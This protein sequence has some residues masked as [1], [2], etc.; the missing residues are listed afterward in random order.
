MSY[1]IGVGLL[2]AG[3]LLGVVSVQGDEVGSQERNSVVRAEVR[4]E[5][6]SAE[7]E[8]RAS[9]GPPGHLERPHDPYV[10]V[11]PERRRTAPALLWS[12]N[13]YVSVQVNV[14]ANGDNIVGD[15][16]NE[17]SI[18]ID[19]TSPSRMVIGWR[20][21]DTIASDFRQAGW[22]YTADGGETWTFPGVI[23]PGVFRSDP[24]LDSDTQ[25][26]FYYNSLTT[27]WTDF[28]CHVFIST[29]GGQSWDAGTYAHGGDKQW[30][31]IDRT[32]G[33]GQDN[34]YADWTSNYS[35]C[36]PGHFTRS[37]DGG[38]TYLACTSIPGDPFWGTLAIGPDGELYVCG[39]GFVVAKSSTMQDAGQPAQWDFT[40]TVNLGGSMGYSGGPNPGGLLGQVW[41]AVDRSDGPTRGNVY[42]L[43]SVDPPGADPLDVMFARSTDGGS[44]W[45][46]PVR[47]NDD[48]STSAYQWFGTMSVA[49]NGRIDIVWSDTRN[50][51]GGYDSE[52][53]YSY[54]G[55][56]G[57]TWSINQALTPAFDPHLG[58]PQQNKLGDYYDMISDDSVAHL[59]YAATFNGEQDVY[60]V[61]ISR[62]LSIGFPNGLPELLTPGE[63]TEITI[64]ILEGDESYVADS[65]TLYH[66]Y[67][68]GTFQ[69]S[70]LVPL[71]GELYRATLPAAYC[72]DTPEYY[73]SAE[74]TESGTLYQP[75]NAP[76]SYYTADVGETVI[77]MADDFDTDQGWTVEN[78]PEL[79]DGAWDRGVPVGG[80]DRGDPPTDYVDDNS[81]VDGGYTWLLSP[82]IDLS[83]GDALVQ[84]ALWYTNNFGGD[85]NNDLFKV[86]VSNDNGVNWTLVSI[87]GPYT[88]S[89]WSVHTFMVGDFLTPTGQVM[90]RFE[91]SDL[92]GGSVV[93][94]GID[95]FAVIR[96][97]C[98]EVECPGDLDGDRDVDLAD[99]AALLANYGTTSGAEYEDGDLDGDGDVDL[100]DLSALLAVYGTTCP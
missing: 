30:M 89:G 72:D 6:Q 22:G 92:A 14:D 64:Q 19:P 74:G 33:I 31:V 90:V 35:V 49:P 29:D 42:L 99:L 57:Q 59:A 53:Y 87:F 54:S 1:R 85:P 66:R 97:V 2:A 11:P 82:T 62:L 27:D 95:D 21:F 56:A 61:R 23:E 76:A 38:Q 86:H 47:V 75:P 39:N 12:R 91:A 52:V 63:P 68:G 24:V 69:T 15:A 48:L 88:S 58:W 46:A 5:S 34:I 9:Q 93:E 32:D 84:Y 77:V 16:A 26:N 80:G 100:S 3:L 94:A 8:T 18:A 4:A 44:T 73:F 67:D 60:Y 37:Y 79:T 40:T 10:P 28:W 51:P 43:C 70:P 78:S 7:Q 81:D 25:G 50:D 65:G 36:Y 96:I 13:G 71:G 17:P 41:I 83:E 55:D 45:S 98:E 20:Q